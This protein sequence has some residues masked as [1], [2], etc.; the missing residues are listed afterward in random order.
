MN[1]KVKWLVSFLLLF[2]FIQAQKVS[3]VYKIDDLLKRINN[4][5][6]TI[7]VINFWATWCKPCVQELPAF[8]EFSE[9]HKAEKIKVLLVTLDFKDELN[10]KVNPF[11]VKSKINLECVLLDEINGN[12]FIEKVYKGWTGAI[13]ATLFT[14]N[15]SKKQVFVEKK[16][17]IE[18]LEDNC[19]KL[20]EK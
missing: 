18:Q 17:G 20:S 10:K 2:G 11:L 19:I 7:Y 14:T 8:V 16:L 13:P 9:K 15:N 3:G 5:G 12:D 4:T 6:D 1:S